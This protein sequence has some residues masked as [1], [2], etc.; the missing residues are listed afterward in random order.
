[1]RRF[2]GGFARLLARMAGWSA[3]RPARGIGAWSVRVPRAS[4]GAE[5]G[6]PYRVFRLLM[7]QGPRRGLQPYRGC[8]GSW[9]ARGH[10]RCRTQCPGGRVGPGRG[11]LLARA[12]AVCAWGSS[13]PAPHR[14]SPKPALAGARPTRGIMGS[15]C[16][17][18]RSVIVRL[19]GMCFRLFPGT[20]CVWCAASASSARH[21]I[22]QPQF[23]KTCVRPCVRAFVSACTCAPRCTFAPCMRADDTLVERR[24]PVGRSKFN[25]HEQQRVGDAGVS[26]YQ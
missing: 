3:R 10:A 26:A 17:C 2:E 11:A 16:V 20:L 12:R 1:M 5:L 9:H 22:R 4:A 21:L 23:L 18:C 8:S 7:G 25:T 13:G 24:R 15:H 14:S 6:P 19:H